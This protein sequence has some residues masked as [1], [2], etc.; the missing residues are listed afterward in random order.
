[1]CSPVIVLVASILSAL[2]LF[3]TGTLVVSLQDLAVLE[4]QQAAQRSAEAAAGVAAE[5]ALARAA[6][7][8]IQARATSEASDL[9]R[10][11]VNRGAVTN[12]SVTRNP[13]AADLANVTVTLVVSYGGLT[14]PLTITATGAASV[15]RP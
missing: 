12:V 9:A 1:M 15:P 7:E 8:V 6:D 2:A 14:G 10:A 3:A 4:T 5:L 13:S 11:N